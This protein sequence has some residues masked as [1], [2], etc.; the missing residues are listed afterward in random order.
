[1]RT[2]LVA[3]VVAAGAFAAATP[4]VAEDG[5]GADF[6]ADA[7]LFYRVVACGGTEPLPATIDA[8]TVS[9][10]CAEMARRYAKGELD[11]KVA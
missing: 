1:M 11:P 6:L 9:A 3:I 4:A 2:S 8:P 10:H 7:K 5:G